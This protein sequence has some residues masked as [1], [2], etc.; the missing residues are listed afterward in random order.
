MFILSREVMRELI[1]KAVEMLN[2][3]G[4]ASYKTGDLEDALESFTESISIKSSDF[5]IYHRGLTYLR[6]NRP[7]LAI[8][9][10]N[11]LICTD[12]CREDVLYVRALAYMQQKTF[13]LAIDDLNSIIHED[14]DHAKALLMRGRIYYFEK[15]EFEAAISDFTRVI[16]LFKDALDGEIDAMGKGLATED[17]LHSDLIQELADIYQLRAY[18]Y[19]IQGDETR[20]LQDYREAHELNPEMSQHFYSRGM[21]YLKSQHNGKALDFFNMAIRLNPDFFQAMTARGMIYAKLRQFDDAIAD[22]NEAL[23]LNNEYA[24]A[25]LQMGLVYHLGLGRLDLA[26]QNYRMANL[27][28]GRFYSSGFFHHMMGV[29][30]APDDPAIDVIPEEPNIDFRQGAR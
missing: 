3:H 16:G 28:D 12:Y 6:L 4:L 1:T 25:Y 17:D 22:F 15:R 27:L 7:E 14:M 26:I 23:R 5:A 8:F 18:A 19:F 2:K 20:A 29:L 10:F 13:D 11:T 9:D 21:T 30:P 24:D